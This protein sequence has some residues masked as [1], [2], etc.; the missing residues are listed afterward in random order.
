MTKYRHIDAQKASYTIEAL[1]AVLDV[2]ESSYY[3]WNHHG[4]AIADARDAREAV[5]VEQIRDAHDA[6]GETYGS[7]MIRAELR[8]A[9]VNISQRRCAELMREHQIVGLSGR[10]HSTVTTRRDRMEAPFPD[11]VQRHFH[12]ALP[13]M[14]WYGDIE[15]H[16]AFLNHAVMKGHRGGVCRSRRRVAEGSLIFGTKRLGGKQP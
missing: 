1:C 14:V 13:D 3:D 8:D 12:P 4:R 7:P 5:L 15:R 9:G 2:P 16:E 11:R 6:S 10:E